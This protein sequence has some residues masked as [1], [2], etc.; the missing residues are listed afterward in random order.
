MLHVLSIYGKLLS[1]GNKYK[2]WCFKFIVI[3]DTFIVGEHADRIFAL[4]RKWIL[5]WYIN[6]VIL[7]ISVIWPL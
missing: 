5:I 7:D 1:T 3:P 4:L 2:Y 6:F